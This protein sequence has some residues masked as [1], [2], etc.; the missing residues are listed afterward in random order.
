MAALVQRLQRARTGTNEAARHTRFGEAE[1]FR[2]GFRGG[3]V[4]PTREAAQHATK[5]AHVAGAGRLPRCVGRQRQHFL[6]QRVLDGLEAQRDQRL[7][8]RLDHRQR[9][10]AIVQRCDGLGIGGWPVCAAI[11]MEAPPEFQRALGQTRN[12][13]SH[14][15]RGAPAER[16]ARRPPS[17]GDRAVG[18]RVGYSFHPNRN[19]YPDM[20]RSRTRALEGR[21]QHRHCDIPRE[22]HGDDLHFHKT[23]RLLPSP[24][25]ATPD[26]FSGVT[27]ITW[28]NRLPR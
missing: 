22:P 21:A 19:S 20:R 23:T 26:R 18:D 7:D 24:I 13:R 5:E 3:F 11:R 12:R 4:L 28:I 14:G 27:S 15:P 8:Q 10:G 17:V 9:H 16:R 1:R 6:R 2:T 25:R